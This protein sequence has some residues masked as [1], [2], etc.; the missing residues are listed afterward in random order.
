MEP[1]RIKSIDAAQPIDAVI[2]DAWELVAA[3]LSRIGF[4]GRT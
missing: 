3:R 2:A 4:P 1:D